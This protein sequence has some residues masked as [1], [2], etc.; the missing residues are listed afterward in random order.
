[1][2]VRPSVNTCQ[3][4]YHQLEHF[5]SIVI[6]SRKA[7]RPNVQVPILADFSCC[8]FER[9]V[10]GAV[11]F[12]LLLHAAIILLIMQA[13]DFNGHP[14]ELPGRQREL[15]HRH[16]LFSMVVFHGVSCTLICF[17]IL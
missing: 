7:P 6:A 17:F 12:A 15:A 11:V 16:L 13:W 9:L 10:V 8:V 4:G 1:M 14:R 3:D 5:Q 2:D